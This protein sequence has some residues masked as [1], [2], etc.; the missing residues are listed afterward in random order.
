MSEAAVIHDRPLA[1]GH[2]LRRPKAT[3]RRR[4]WLA[5]VVTQLWPALLFL[6][7]LMGFPADAGGQSLGRVRWQVMGDDC[8]FD[9]ARHRRLTDLRPALSCD[10]LETRA[11]RGTYAYVATA[12]PPTVVI[13]ELQITQT[14]RSSQ[15]GMQLLVRVV[16]PRTPDTATGQPTTVLLAGDMYEAPNTWQSLTLRNIDVELADKVRILRSASQRPVDAREAFC[17]LV[18]VNI[19]GKPGGN[20]LA[21]RDPVVEGSTTS[22]VA[23]RSTGLPATFASHQ[24]RETDAPPTRPRVVGDTLIANG[25]PLFV[26]AIDARGEEWTFL[27]ELGFNTIRLS[28]PVSQEQVLEAERLGLWLIAPPPE[29]WPAGNPAALYR[30][31]LAWTFGQVDHPQQLRRMADSAARARAASQFAGRPLLVQTDTFSAA[32]AEHAD[33]L[34]FGRDPLHGD[35]SLRDYQRWLT[36]QRRGTPAGTVTWATVQ[37]QPLAMVEAQLRAF[38]YDFQESPFAIEPADLDAH[39]L[40]AATTGQRGVVFT[41]YRRLDLDDDATRLRVAE[42]RH[43]NERL[44][45]LEPWLAAGEPIAIDTGHRRDFLVTALRTERAWLVVA[46]YVGEEETASAAD[47]QVTVPGA[48]ES[49]EAFELLPEGLRRMP[50][51]RSPG[52]VRL[53]LPAGKH[54]L[55]ILSREALVIANVERRVQRSTGVMAELTSQIGESLYERTERLVGGLAGADRAVVE[56]ELRKVAKDLSACRSL[57]ANGEF[58]RMQSLATSAVT[59]LGRTRRALHRRARR[60]PERTPLNEYVDG[61]PLQASFLSRT[62]AAGGPVNLLSIGE[63]ESDRVFGSEGWQ[64]YQDASAQI[65]VSIEP[66]DDPAAS[67][68]HCLRVSPAPLA[69]QRSTIVSSRRAWLESPPI[70]V[71]AQEIY[72]IEGRVRSEGLM[73]YDGPIIRVYDSLAGPQLGFEANRTDGWRSFSFLHAAVAPGELTVTIELAAPGNVWI[74]ELRV[75]QLATPRGGEST[76]RR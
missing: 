65:V 1:C 9:V 24:R 43:L 70:P 25:R 54:T 4:P 67:G 73:G 38:G 74:D 29:Q 55:A 17:D 27:K 3:D 60:A 8:G 69:T 71:S 31:V 41:S 66:A 34:L 14:L 39:A 62:V 52:G 68:R 36:D 2:D 64:V 22:M 15:A 44:Q 18:I 57:A 76:A 12:I 35:V 61:L 11:G 63:F 10:L 45:W 19:Y 51:R 16:L 32:C 48:S 26:R 50:Q 20:E 59:Q 56:D 37:N 58:T 72:R 40:L 33:L 75:N 5:L 21:L 28:H 23:T 13:P 42:L 46:L 49:C 30:R 47:L 7:P 6:L 53:Q